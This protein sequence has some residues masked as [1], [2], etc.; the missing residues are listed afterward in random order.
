MPSWPST[1]IIANQ[2]FISGVVEAIV[3]KF[4]AGL[5]IPGAEP[6]RQPDSR[7]PSRRDVSVLKI[8]EGTIVERDSV[9]TQH[10]IP[11]AGR[12]WCVPPPAMTLPRGT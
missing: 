10:W 1:L 3:P 6:G 11:Q 5:V 4:R 7:H 12:L 9:V 8:T 2:T